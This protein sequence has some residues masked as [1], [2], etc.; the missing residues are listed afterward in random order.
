MRQGKTRGFLPVLAALAGNTAIAVLKWVG[1][2]MTGSGAMFSEAVHSVA[3]ILNQIFLMVG[4]RRS[5]K[6]SDG[7]YP[8]GYA[9]ERFFWAV[10]SACSIF[11][12]GSG[13]TV[14][15]GIAVLSEGGAVHANPFAILVLVVSL[16]VESGTF[17]VALR[18]LR[19]HGK[20]KPLSEILE[21]GD[22]TTIAVLYEDGLAVVGVLVALGSILLSYFTGQSFWDAV[23]SIVIGA[24]LGIM[25]VML[26]AKN[27]SFLIRRSVPEDIAERV[28]EIIKSDSAIERVLDFKSVV[29]DVGMYHVKCEVEV[30]G[31]ALMRDMYRGKAL[32]NA[33]GDIGTEYDD[34]LR[35]CVD[36][37]DRIPRMIG[38][39]VDE[40]ERKIKEEI[41]EVRHIDI[42]VN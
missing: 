40:V 14:Y 16:V 9:G 6:P 39:R 22:P 3:D 1:F 18:E 23:G 31:S 36:F 20:G 37:A 32:R 26:I 29:I 42:E 12:L 33:F 24:L 17:L 4:I 28:Q 19:R 38:T 8:Y 25:A 10:L 27:R 5:Q 21:E 30:N 7:D 13:V 15:H 11:F 35:F 2:F 41:P 34:F